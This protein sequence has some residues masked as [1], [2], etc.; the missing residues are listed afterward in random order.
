V[1]VTVNSPRL[2]RPDLRLATALA[3]GKITVALSRRLGV[4]GGTTLP[5][6]VTRRIDPGVLAKL[7]HALREGAIVITGTNGKTTTSRLVSTVLQKSGRQVIHNRTGANLLPGVVSALV[8]E[9]NLEGKPGGDI[10]LFEVDE[11]SVPPVVRGLQ[12]RVF[13]VTN[14]F[15]DQLDRYG[16]VDYVASIW[17]RALQDLTRT[18]TVVLNADDPSVAALGEALPAS[19][20][21]FGVNDQRHGRSAPEHAA[22]A[23]RCWRCHA[24]Y[25]YTTTYYG[26]VG[27]YRCSKCGWS[28]P[29]PNIIADDIELDGMAGCRFRLVTPAGSTD[30]KLPLPGLYNVYNALAA[31]ATCFAVGIPMSDVAVALSRFSAAFGRIE[32]IEIDGRTVYLAL[33]KNPIGFNQVVRTILL[34]PGQRQLA[35]I[36]NDNFADGTDISWLWDVDFEELAGRVASGT[37]GGTR[38]EDMLLRLKY[39]GVDPLKMTL[40][41][42]PAET[43]DQALEKLE[44]GETL[45]VLPTYTAMLELRQV[46]SDRGLV[47]PFWEN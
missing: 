18:A 43:F 39:A 6:H 47:V 4:G 15:R 1:N 25:E 5:G 34:Q 41:R 14:L 37:I 46:L 28:R 36:I 8:Q 17:R 7:G 32:R 2:R 10:G 44:P 21:Y 24:P 22:D 31:A 23:R 33:V 20:I 19:P 26:H 3:A 30:V 27:H 13:C 35:I 42:S 45:Y 16:E 9:T 29:M 40:C 11:A 38:A 12:P